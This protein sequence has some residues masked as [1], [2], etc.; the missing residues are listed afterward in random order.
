MWAASAG[1]RSDGSGVPLV[2][3][4]QNSALAG[5]EYARE[6]AARIPHPTLTIRPGNSWGI[7]LGHAEVLIAQVTRF[8]LG[9]AASSSATAGVTHTIR[10]ADFAAAPIMVAPARPACGLGGHRSR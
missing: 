2:L 4:P 5:P 9:P 7:M 8:A 6:A 1:A 10:F 3:Q